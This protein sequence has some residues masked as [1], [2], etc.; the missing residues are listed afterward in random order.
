MYSATKMNL[1]ARVCTVFKD[2]NLVHDQQILLRGTG[3]WY[4]FV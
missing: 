2:P 3:V 4:L 1:D